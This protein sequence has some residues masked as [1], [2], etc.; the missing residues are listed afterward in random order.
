MSNE[1]KNNMIEASRKEGQTLANLTSSQRDELN[2]KIKNLKGIKKTLAIQEFLKQ[3][4][5]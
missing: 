1:I 2:V 3:L 4:K 5:K